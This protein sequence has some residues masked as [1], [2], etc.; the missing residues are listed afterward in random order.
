MGTHKFFLEPAEEGLK[1]ALKR[2]PLG[3]VNL[4][5]HHSQ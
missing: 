2:Q 4:G 3:D 1:L 5:L